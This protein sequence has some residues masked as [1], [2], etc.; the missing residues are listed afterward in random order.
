MESRLNIKKQII[1]VLSFV[2][3]ALCLVIF[4]QNAFANTLEKE[5]NDTI[6][7]SQLLVT[8]PMSSYSKNP[9]IGTISSKND[10]DYYKFMLDEPGIVDVNFFGKYNFSTSGGW[11]VELLDGKN[12]CYYKEE[13]LGN[14]Q[15][16]DYYVSNRYGL[17]AGTYYIRISSLNGINTDE[18]YWVCVRYN[19]A[20]TMEKENNNSKKTANKLSGELDGIIHSD[21]DVDYYEI[22]VKNKGYVSYSLESLYYNDYNGAEGSVTFYYINGQEMAPLSGQSNDRK[23]WKSYSIS[24]GKYYFK[25]TGDK[26]FQYTILVYIYESNDYEEEL[27]DTIQNSSELFYDDW[28]NEYSSNGN[29]Y[30]DKDIDYYKF[31]IENAS[32]IKLTFDHEY[33]STYSGWTITLL[34]ENGKELYKKNTRACDY[35]PVESEEYLVPRGKYYIRI[36][37]FYSATDVMYELKV[38]STFSEEG[39]VRFFV[40]RFYNTI[41]GRE[42][43]K[44]GLDDW[45]NKLVT[46]E[47]TGADVA[48]GFILSTE[49][50]NKNYS[51]DIFVNKMYEAFFDRE[52]D[53]GGYNGWIAKLNAGYSREYVL[54]GFIN[55]QEFRN[56]CDRYG[57]NPGKL[58]VNE[59]QNNNQNNNN[60]NNNQN[61]IQPSSSLK[62]LNVD[63][64]GVNDEQLTAFVERLY[65]KALGRNE[66]DA[67]GVAYWKGCILNGQDAQGRQ[68][69][70]RTVI[71]KGFFC[72]REYANQMNSDEKFL[73]DC[74][75]A[76]FNRDPDEN[77][78]NYWLGQMHNGVTRQEVIEHGFGDSIEFRNLIKSYGFVIIE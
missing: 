14:R 39:E 64:S 20:T 41:L 25:V 77:G 10:V 34:D 17:D 24:P 78:Y 67:E 43:E 62:P 9:A 15:R 16:S 58:D 26:D 23:E 32:N 57:I 4:K 11:T 72:S 63:T 46:K 44:E 66:I 53:E 8:T 74:Y 47:K 13:F 42:A 69:D 3:I 75:A 12:N 19:N 48:R 27:N 2:F 22:D 52:A 40:E 50:K 68:Y 6:K 71:S 65:I 33:E 45:T 18:E 5:P 36:E 70:I 60:Q 55:S 1:I 49:F 51:D 59:P 37:P 7:T 29:L 30:N 76:F 31:Y 56:L 35:D 54:A 28:E 73:T 61:N 21:D 38:S